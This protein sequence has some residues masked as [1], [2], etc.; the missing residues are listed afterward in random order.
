MVTPTFYVMKSLQCQGWF[1]VHCYNIHIHSDV[2]PES[3]N[4]EDDGSHTHISGISIILRSVNI[5]FL[6]TF[7]CSEL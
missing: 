7:H 5:F 1:I 6:F 4:N 3:T 2:N